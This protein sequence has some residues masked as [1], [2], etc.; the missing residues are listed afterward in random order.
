MAWIFC[1]LLCFSS[2]CNRLH[3]GV[4]FWLLACRTPVPHPFIMVAVFKGW[5]G[6]RL[7]P[8]CRHPC[9]VTWLP[10]SF[11]LSSVGIYSVL[12]LL[13]TRVLVSTLIF[14]SF[15]TQP[16]WPDHRKTTPETPDFPLCHLCLTAK[17]T[18]AL[19]WT[20]NETGGGASAPTASYF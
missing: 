20:K 5:K 17:L 12:H 10:Q 8:D 19:G 18:E 15:A 4:E 16:Q 9:G 3:L 7:L 14:L 2:L 6:S 11:V 1:T 13:K